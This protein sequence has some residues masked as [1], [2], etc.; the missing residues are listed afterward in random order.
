SSSYNKIYGNN[1]TN[2][3]EGVSLYSSFHNTIS[4][5]NVTS[6]NGYGVYLDYSYYN[7]IDG[8]VIINN[9]EGVTLE[10]SSYNTISSNVITLNND[11]GIV[12]E[13]SEHTSTNNSVYGNCITDSYYGVI[14][15]YSYYNTISG[16]NVTNNTHGVSLHAS[17][18]N[19]VTGNN[20]T[21]N[22]LDGVILYDSSRNTVSG[23]NITANI[24]AGVYLYSSGNN[25]ICGNNVTDNGYGAYLDDSLYN[26]MYHNHFINNTIQVFADN[27]TWNGWDDGYPSGGNYWSDHPCIDDDHDDICDSPYVIN[28][29]N[30]DNY[31]IIPEFPSLILLPL[32]M[33]GTL[34][35]AVLFRKKRRESHE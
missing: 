22:L 11:C 12:L 30:V 34:P 6:N 28:E 13:S 18:K 14:L 27:A 35:A 25:T 33:L 10:D 1:I 29:N 17:S 2:N 20:I 19:T 5:N 16:N 26:Y 24:K 7:T 3:F 4:G 31:P 32:F 9:D 8:N 21:S 23:N 15:D